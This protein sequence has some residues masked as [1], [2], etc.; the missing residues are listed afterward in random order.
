MGITATIKIKPKKVT[1]VAN[2]TTLFLNATVKKATKQEIVASVNN[3][4]IQTSVPIALKNHFAD[5]PFLSQIRDVDVGTLI[6]GG[7][8][9]YNASLNKYEIRPVEFTTTNVD[10]GYF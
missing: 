4:R 7:V 1:V 3:G 8:L 5:F 6:D 2:N 10:G 9:S